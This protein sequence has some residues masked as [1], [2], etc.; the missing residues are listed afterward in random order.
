MAEPDSTHSTYKRHPTYWELETRSFVYRVEETLYF[1]PLAVLT[2]M[3]PPLTAIFGIPAVPPAMDASGNEEGTEANPII[4]PGITAKQFDDFLSYFFKSGL[5]PVETLLP[6]RVEEI[7]VNLLTVGCLW[8]IHQ[9]TTYAKEVL[10]GLNL[11]PCRILELA[12]GFAVHEWVE[13]AVRAL[14]PV[15]GEL[16]TNQ[17]LQ[18]GPITL[19]ILFRAK[20]AIDYERLCVAYVS[21]KLTT[22]DDLNYGDCGTHKTCE[23]V[24]RENWWTLVGKKI[25]HPK[26]PMELRN[27]GAHLNSLSFPGM[28]PHC[29]EDAVNKWT[30]NIFEEDGITT[31][32]VAGVMEFNKFCR[33]S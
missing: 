18:L 12:R 13:A 32:A 7:A 8:D 2:M 29:H 22:A 5:I 19:N 21:P 31:A 16:T 30:A 25:L 4:I 15:C 23:R 33:P 17:A 20:T 3:S 9:A 10:G 24:W 26:N 28:T 11:A 14:I 1:F 6:R 27:V